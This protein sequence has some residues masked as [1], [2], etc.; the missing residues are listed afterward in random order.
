LIHSNMLKR[1]DLK[2]T[3]HSIKQKGEWKSERSEK[4]V[5]LYIKSQRRLEIQWGCG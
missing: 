5:Q 3:D 1:N 4:R 2:H